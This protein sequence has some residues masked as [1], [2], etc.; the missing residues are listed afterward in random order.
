MTGQSWIRRHRLLSCAVL[1]LG[2][3]AGLIWWCFETDIASARARAAEG[4]IVL[5]TRCGPIEYQDAGAGVPLLAVHGSGGGH[6]QGM[7]FASPLTKRGIRVIA[8]SRFGYLSTPMPAEASAAAQADAHVCLLDA[9]GIT[10]A[11]VLGGSAGAPSA[12]AMAIRHPDRTSALILLV[13][14]TYKPPTLAASAPTMPSWVEKAMMSV[15]GSDFLFWSALHEGVCASVV[16]GVDTSPV[17]QATEHDLDLVSLSVERGVVRDGDP[18]VAL[19]GDAGG[20]SALG[21]GVPE[22]VGVITSVA[23]QV[24]GPWQGIDH[25]GSSLVVAHLSLAEQQDERATQMVADRMELRVQAAL[26]A[27]DTSGKS[28]LFKRLAAVRCAFRW[29]A[30]IMIVSGSPTFA[31]SSAKMRLNTPSRL[32]RMK[33]L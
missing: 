6:D 19:R 30:S 27:P 22:P 28:P 15:I 32:Q 5:Q 3:I 31:A 18:A 10:K 26:G 16:A 12:L 11:A 24:L 4:S 29:V 17:F 8:M 1:V 13:P 23:D 21:E 9:L 33:R 7:A 14:L 20:G 2:I 25:Q